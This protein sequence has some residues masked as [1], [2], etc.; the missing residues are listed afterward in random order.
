[1]TTHTGRTPLPRTSKQRHQ[2]SNGRLVDLRAVVKTY[3]SAAGTFG[4]LRA[5]DLQ[6]KSGA[7]VS[8][9]QV[10][11]AASP[12]LIQR[13]SPGIRP[14]HIGRVMVEGVTASQPE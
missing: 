6:V 14:P 10:G 2:A 12:T 4:A 11:P 8:I 5:L 3:S 7:F 9:V 1:V 13:S